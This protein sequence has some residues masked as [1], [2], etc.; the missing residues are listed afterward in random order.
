MYSYFDSELAQNILN[1]LVEEYKNGNTKG[2]NQKKL[3]TIFGCNVGVLATSLHG[4]VA[5]DFLNSI[6]FNNNTKSFA[7][8]KK[9][10]KL[11]EKCN[12]ESDCLKVNEPLNRSFRN[13]VIYRVPVE[14]A[15]DTKF[16]ATLPSRV[17]ID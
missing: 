14:V 12:F 9:A 7:L 1:T 10:V 17:S 5:R 2:L 6:G 15:R 8:S 13:C 4:L 11:L 16:M 3:R